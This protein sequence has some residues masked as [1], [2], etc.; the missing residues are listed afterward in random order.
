MERNDFCAFILT[1][2]R[3]DNVITYNTLLRAGYTGPIFLIVDDGD[4]QLPRYRELYGDKVL[5]FSK[6]EIAKTFDEGDNFK[7]RKTI[8]Y[9]RNVSFEFAKKLGFRFFIQLDDDYT[10]FSYSSNQDT[11]Y[12]V[13]NITMR[14]FDEVVNIFLEFL[15]NTNITSIAFSQGGDHIGGIN[16]TKNKTIQLTRK[17][18]NSFFCDTTKPFKFVGRINEDVNTYTELQRR[19]SV[20]F[21]S[22]QTKLVQ[23]QTQTNSGG[24]T[25]TYMHSGTYVKSFYSVMY[26][27]SAVKVSYLQ[28]RATNDARI[29][30]AVTWNSCAP[31]ILRESVRKKR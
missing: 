4:A 28:D 9:A 25:D 16:A 29:H 13:S 8:I 30:H 6:E 14:S 22:M 15:S 10:Y 11:S 3:A 31:K 21:T 19:G 27:P 5:V 1:H 18:M 24:M 20:F 2:G 7:K 12:S 23:K 17:C 26:C